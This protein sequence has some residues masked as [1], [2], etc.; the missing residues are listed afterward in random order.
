MQLDTTDETSVAKPQPKGEKVKSV[1]TLERRIAV[2]R[3]EFE[4]DEQTFMNSITHKHRFKEAE[5]GFAASGHLM[6]LDQERKNCGFSL[7][8]RFA[9]LCIRGSV[10]LLSLTLVDGPANVL[11]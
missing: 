2:S 9:S 10:E 6:T 1:K 4:Q 3:Q 11:I 5:A 8:Y 7:S